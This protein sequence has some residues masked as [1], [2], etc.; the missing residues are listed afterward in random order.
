MKTKEA[1]QLIVNEMSK[2][3]G[4]KMSN[5]CVV[6]SYLVIGVKLGKLTASEAAKE[7]NKNHEESCSI[8]FNRYQ[9]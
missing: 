3:L 1:K 2:Q 9:A 5:D 7:T 4:F 6:E 8:V